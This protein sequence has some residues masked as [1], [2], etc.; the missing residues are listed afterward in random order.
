MIVS[1]G[2]LNAYSIHLDFLFF[3]L[4]YISILFYP[5]LKCGVLMGGDRYLVC[6]MVLCM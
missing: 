4:F 2:F 3:I 6:V 1:G 5:F